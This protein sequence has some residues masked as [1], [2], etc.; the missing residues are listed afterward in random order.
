[1]WARPAALDLVEQERAGAVL[2]NGENEALAVAPSRR[3]RAMD[4][5]QTLA[6]G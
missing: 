6:R 4:A 3:R 2:E 1:M 5:L